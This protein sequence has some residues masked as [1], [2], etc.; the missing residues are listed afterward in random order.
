MHA[1]EAHRH[2]RPAARARPRSP[3]SGTESAVTASGVS[4]NNGMDVGQRQ[5]AEAPDHEA[6]LQDQQEGAEELQPWPSGAQ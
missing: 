3:R 6:D 5:L 2:R 1:H 4:A